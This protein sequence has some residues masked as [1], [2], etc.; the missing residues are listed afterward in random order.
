MHCSQNVQENQ[1]PLA[2]AGA[3]RSLILQ[4]VNQ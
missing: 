4:R 1:M 3:Q 2:L